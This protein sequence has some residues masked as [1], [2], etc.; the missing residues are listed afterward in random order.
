MRGEKESFYKIEN[1]ETSTDIKTSPILHRSNRFVGS[2]QLGAPS[3]MEIKALKP[4]VK[5]YPYILFL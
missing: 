3:L 1:K 5:M 4:S 2:T